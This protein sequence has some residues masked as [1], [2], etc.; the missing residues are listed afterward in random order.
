MNDGGRQGQDRGVTSTMAMMRAPRAKGCLLPHVVGAGLD[1]DGVV[2][3]CG[4]LREF[5]TVRCADFRPQ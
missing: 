4:Q 3:A 1:P 5:A 2:D